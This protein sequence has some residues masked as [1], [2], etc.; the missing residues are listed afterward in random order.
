MDVVEI[1]IDQIDADDSWNCRGHIAPID[2]AELAE[3]IRDK[4]LIQPGVVMPHPKPE[5][6]FKYKLVAGFRRRMA[7]AVL[8][9]K[10]YPCVIREDLT[11]EDAMFMNLNENIQ[12]SQLNILQEAKTIA[13]IKFFNPKIGRTGCAA[14]LN[15]SQ[16][17]VQI[18]EMLLNLPEEIQQ[19]VVVGLI[20]QTQVRELNTI[21]RGEGR[22]KCYEAAK[23][24]KKAKQAGRKPRIKM[25]KNRNKIKQRGRDE[26]FDMMA[27][28]NDSVPYSD[29]DKKYLWPRFAS[30]AAGEISD[31][32]LF[33]SAKE[34]ADQEGHIWVTPECDA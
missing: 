33:E 13:K 25:K 7:Y 29:G 32:D 15:M 19:E 20:T 10:M 5:K 23:E 24:M 14:K 26:I 6:G 34:F 3:S 18:R 17:W 11:E 12:R 31:N 22:E 4:G 21:M 2:V 30:W 8:K 28:I 9:K 16:G 1:N 27:D